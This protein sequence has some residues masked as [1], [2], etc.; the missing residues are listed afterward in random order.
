MNKIK[1]K[2]IT[3]CWCLEVDINY[4]FQSFLKG[5]S[6]ALYSI[7][8]LFFITSLTLMYSNIKRKFDLRF[9]WMWQVPV[10][11]DT[12]TADSAS[13]LFLSHYEFSPA[14]MYSRQQLELAHCEEASHLVL[15]HFYTGALSRHAWLTAETPYLP[16]QFSYVI[17]TNAF[18]IRN[19]IAK[20]VFKFLN[21]P[22]QQFIHSNHIDMLYILYVSLCY[23]SF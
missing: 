15:I 2:L 14:N 21:L 10:F 22:S 13:Q 18:L 20:A 3:L 8:T 16:V 5:A 4:S 17:E 9:H 7:F 19:R 12:S 11:Y 6:A 23:T 1:Y